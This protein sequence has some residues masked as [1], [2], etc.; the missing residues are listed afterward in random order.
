ME[1][2]SYYDRSATIFAS[3]K[4]GRSRTIANGLEVVPHAGAKRGN[5]KL[6]IHDV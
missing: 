6:L 4:S 2:R 1:L 3:S 5:M